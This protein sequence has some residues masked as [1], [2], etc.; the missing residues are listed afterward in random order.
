MQ[1]YRTETTPIH[2]ATARIRNTECVQ[3]MGQAK[4]SIDTTRNS[5]SGGEDPDGNHSVART[6][7][8]KTTIRLVDAVALGIWES[9]MT[10]HGR[11][12]L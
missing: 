12:L 11:E 4:W 8:P 9:L 6:R 10:I 2:A 5:K 3:V 1:V 7:H